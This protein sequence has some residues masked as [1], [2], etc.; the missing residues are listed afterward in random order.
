MT[1]SPDI[2]A[3]LPPNKELPKII[4]AQKEKLSPLSKN[5]KGIGVSRKQLED[6]AA[7]KPVLE[8]VAEQTISHEHATQLLNE[9]NAL[10][11]DMKDLRLLVSSLATQAADTPLGNQMQMESLRMLKELSPETI[12]LDLVPRLTALQL[13]LNALPIQHAN[14]ENNPLISTIQQYNVTHPDSRVSE[15]LLSQIQSGDVKSPELVAQILQSNQPL[16][17]I[18]WKEL[19][20]QPNFKGFAPTKEIMLDLAG[21]EHSPA[22]LEKAQ[23]I[24]DQTLPLKEKPD[25]VSQLMSGALVG[26]LT[27]MFVSQMAAP[28]GQQQGGH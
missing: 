15:E 28:E 18:V 10:L 12:P 1:G 6:I 8:A 25:M 22:N 7:G 21:F 20:G 16:A 17:Q 11:L 5:K 2:Q 3:S 19:T 13:K 24:V 4:P 9:A 23:A 26:A 14:P 27:I